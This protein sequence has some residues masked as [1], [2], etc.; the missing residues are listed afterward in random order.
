MSVQAISASYLRLIL[1]AAVPV[2]VLLTNFRAALSSA[3]FAAEYRMPGFPS[4]DY[5]FTID[6][7][8]K[9]SSAVSS[10]L[11]GNSNTQELA[12]LRI[13]LEQ[14]PPGRDAADRTLLFNAREVRHLEDTRSVMVKSL[15][16]WG[17]ACIIVLAASY[18][19]GRHGGARALEDAWFHATLITCGL[20]IGGALLFLF[21]FD[22]I[23]DALHG[24]LFPHGS[25]LFFASDSL[26]RLFPP[27]FWQ[28]FFLFVPLA[29]LTES[30]GLATVLGMRKWKRRHV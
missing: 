19:I 29:T 17:L 11:R 25:Y 9:W 27:R 23:F 8:L 5:G 30:A 18:A 15:Q 14:S 2:A 6:D 24:A 28:D 3:F 10:Y 7:R 12:A 22:P 13:A 20:T 26:I 16:I 21:D 1:I 4:D